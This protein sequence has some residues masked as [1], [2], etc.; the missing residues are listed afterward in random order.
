[1]RAEIQ[2]L[3][4]NGTWTW[5]LTARPASQRA[6]EN[7]WVYKIKHR[8]D[9]SIERYK[10]HLVVLGD[11]QREGIDYNETFAQV[12][13]MDTLRTLLAVAA[14]KRWEIHQI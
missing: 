13:K 4:N 3:E 14:S 9:G 1:M 12:A 8:S 6:I 7:K 11:N 5:T 10:A 2:A